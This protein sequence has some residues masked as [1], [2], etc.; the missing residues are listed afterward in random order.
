MTT[1]S[2]ASA[3]QSCSQKML[4]RARRTALPSCDRAAGSALRCAA[5]G[6]LDEVSV[7]DFSADK[8]LP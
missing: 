7:T 1:A 2:R 5:A 4:Q 6:W 8:I 3:G